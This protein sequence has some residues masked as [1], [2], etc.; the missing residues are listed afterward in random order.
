MQNPKSFTTITIILT[1]L[2]GKYHFL[3]DQSTI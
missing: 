1:S 2:S 3:I